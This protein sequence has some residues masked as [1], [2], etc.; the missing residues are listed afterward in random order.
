M[1]LAIRFES[2][3]GIPEA[4]QFVGLASVATALVGEIKLSLKS[5]LEKKL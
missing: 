5:L 3:A 1:L 4:E 2:A